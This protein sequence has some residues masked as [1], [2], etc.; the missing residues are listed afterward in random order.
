M[1]NKQGRR[2]ASVFVSTRRRRF[3]G[4]LKRRGKCTRVQIRG[5]HSGRHASH[6]GTGLRHDGC[7]WHRH[8]CGMPH[9]GGTGPMHWR[10]AV[11]AA[12]LRSQ[13]LSSDRVVFRGW[14][15]PLQT[16]RWV[17]VYIPS[18]RYLSCRPTCVTTNYTKCQ[19]NP[20][21]FGRRVSRSCLCFLEIA[22]LSLF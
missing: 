19:S 13:L 20:T 9:V 1:R 6:V 12:E 21:F 10:G 14:M 18:A 17:V 11:D 3:K 16:L 22:I 15:R 2:R 8:K 4:A 5:S 7:C